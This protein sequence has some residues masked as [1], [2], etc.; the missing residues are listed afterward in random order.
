MSSARFEYLEL[1]RPLQRRIKNQRAEIRRLQAYELWYAKY[2]YGK[3]APET[4]TNTG[5]GGRFC[6]A[7]SGENCKLGWAECQ[8]RAELA[9]ALGE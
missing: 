7:A 9:T 4:L 8:R 6:P 1:L 5:C 3:Q 2:V